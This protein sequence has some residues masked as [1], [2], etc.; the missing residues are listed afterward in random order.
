MK[1]SLVGLSVALCLGSLLILTA[2]PVSAQSV[3]AGT[4]SGQVTD[5]QTAAIVGAEVTLTDISTNTA[6]ATKTNEVGRCIFLNVAPGTYNLA[7]SQPG[8]LNHFQP[9]NPTLS[10]DSPGSFSVV[11]GHTSNG[12][13]LP[14]ILLSV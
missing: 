2:P 7:V 4:V 3:S 10:I 12:I 13:R 11:T 8:L 6:Q 9:A 5:L 1:E 14:D